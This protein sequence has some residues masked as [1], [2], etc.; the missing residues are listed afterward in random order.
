[1]IKKAVIF[2][3]DDTLYGYSSLNQQALEMVFAA[4]GQRFSCAAESVAYAFGLART[5]IKKH[6]GPT[7]SSH[8]RLLYFQK[9]LEHLQ[10]NPLSYSL[11]MYE[12]YWNYMLEHMTLYDGVLDIM[13]FCMETGIKIGI[14]TDLTAHI[15]HKKIRKLGIAAYISALV[16]SEEAGCDKPDQKIFSMILKKLDVLP[17]ES[18]YVGDSLEKDIIGAQKCGMDAVW[19]RQKEE[20]G[21]VTVGHIREVKELLL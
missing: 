21:I 16:T 2:D 10:Q 3:L 19:F 8:N 17:Y 20:E 12:L 7:A 4:A 14:C 15:Q 5:E 18:L 11:E 9:T 13:D 1:M 6:L